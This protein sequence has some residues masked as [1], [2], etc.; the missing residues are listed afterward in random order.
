M[1]LVARVLNWLLRRFERRHLLHATPAQ[2]R[3]G[4]ETKSRLFAHM[5]RGSEV[6]TL[7]LTD[8]TARVPSLCIT[9]PGADARHTL[10][11]FHGGAYVFGSPNTHR[12]MLG[13]LSRLSG[14]QAI[15]PDYRMAPEH[16][17]PAA[18]EDA[19]IAWRVLLD[20]GIAPERMVMGGDSAGGGLVLALLGELIRTGAPLPAGVFAFSPLT[21]LT[22]SGDSY[23]HNDDREVMLP[24]ERA[25]ELAALFLAGHDPE[26]ARASPLF[27]DFTGAPPVYLTVGDTEILLDDTRRI[28]ARMRAQGVDVSEE[29]GRDLPHV[30]PM[31]HIVLPEARAT[32]RE[33]AGWIRRRPGWP[34][35]N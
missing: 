22:F 17:F 6:K 1:S 9:A 11:Y 25:T 21:D 18:L 31:M 26:D 29:I 20:S 5:P 15:L 12:G 24:G 10:L 27:A 4:F 34:V 23:R 2:L 33:V 28:A 30:W 35:E 32:L 7:T 16:P 13:Q 3:R 19:L 14:A 8:G